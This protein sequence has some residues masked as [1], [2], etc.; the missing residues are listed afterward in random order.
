MC[1]I[2][3]KV[4]AAPV[5]RNTIEAMTHALHHRGPDD[6]DVWVG[7]GAALGSRR[8]AIIDLSPRGRMPMTNEDGSLRLVYNG[9]IYNY[10]ELREDLERR[11]HVFQ[12]DT[13]TETILHAYEEYGTDAITRFGGMFAFALWDV[14]RRRLGSSRSPREETL[15]YGSAVQSC[16][17]RPSSVR[18][19]EIRDRSCAGHRGTA[20]LPHWGVVPAPRA[21]LRVS[22]TSSRHHLVFRTARSRLS[23]TGACRINPRGGV[24]KINS[25]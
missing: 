7:D 19:S 12:S 15:L 11:G 24:Q 3:G 10:R 1:G 4:S 2:A 5:E 23:G 18:C 13:D 17:S 22:G 21:P 16:H 25:R 8:L 20:S 9:E 14:R 6:G